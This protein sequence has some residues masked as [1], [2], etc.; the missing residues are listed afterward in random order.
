MHGVLPLDRAS[1][2]KILFELLEL[3][4]N[5]AVVRLIDELRKKGHPNGQEL[6][7]EIRCLFNL[8][9]VEALQNTR[10]RFE[11]E[12]EKLTEF[13]IGLL[14]FLVLELLRNSEE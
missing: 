3:R 10:V 4:K 9:C 2:A 14:R 6:T 8:W 7:C 1:R 12:L 5:I 13:P 11:R